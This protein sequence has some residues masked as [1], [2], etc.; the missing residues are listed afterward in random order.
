MLLGFRMGRDMDF[1]PNYPQARTLLVYAH[2]LPCS[3]PDRGLWLRAMMGLIDL[4]CLRRVRV[5]ACHRMIYTP[6][7]NR[8]G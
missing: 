5:R 6:S 8:R 1:A 2:V 3:L 7:I 4:A